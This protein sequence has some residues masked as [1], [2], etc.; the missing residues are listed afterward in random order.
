VLHTGTGKHLISQLHKLLHIALVSI[1]HL[2]QSYARKPLYLPW[3]EIKGKNHT[4]HEGF[5]FLQHTVLQW[6]DNVYKSTVSAG[7]NW[8]YLL[9]P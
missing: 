2:L 3:I 6:T 1:I 5:V 4:D 9:C 8:T 7:S